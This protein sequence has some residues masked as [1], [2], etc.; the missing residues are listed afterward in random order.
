[1]GLVEAGGGPRA[2]HA[3]DTRRDPSKDGQPRNDRASS[4]HSSAGTDDA[5]GACHS[6]QLFRPNQSSHRYP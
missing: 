1:M 5:A 3:S 6:R 2:V 4:A